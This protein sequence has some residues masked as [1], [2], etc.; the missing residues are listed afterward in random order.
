MSF[1][2]SR[3]NIDIT[4]FI[5]PNVT[6]TIDQRCRLYKISVIPPLFSTLYS[7]SLYTYLTNESF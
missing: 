6:Q 4:S 2:G 7:K 3:F 1:E 5:P